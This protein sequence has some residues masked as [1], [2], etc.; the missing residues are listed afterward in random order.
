MESAASH[1][2]RR[3]KERTDSY[4]H[5]FTM[6]ITACRL[7]P[8][9][10][11]NNRAG[12]LNTWGEVAWPSGLTATL[13]LLPE[14]VCRGGLHVLGIASRSIRISRSGMFLSC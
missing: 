1:D 2:N 6:G 5:A 9:L 8:E 10:G 12:R 4:M 13:A 3:C 11:G 14:K 7:N